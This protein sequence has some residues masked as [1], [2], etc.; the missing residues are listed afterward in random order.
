MKKSFEKAA[1]IAIQH[2]T[3]NP[4]AEERSRQFVEI[5]RSADYYEG[6]AVGLLTALDF[7]GCGPETNIDIKQR[8][9][10]CVAGKAAELRSV[11]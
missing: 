9:I 5:G 6:M 10:M 8:A 1:Q 11:A 4:M 2:I 7:L 3:D